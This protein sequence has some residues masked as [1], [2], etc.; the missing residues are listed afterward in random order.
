[1]ISRLLFMTKLIL[2]YAYFHSL[3]HN[4]LR[5]NFSKKLE[6][7]FLFEKNQFILLPD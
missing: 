7:C 6:N 4:G 3:I 1:M 5:N 2:I